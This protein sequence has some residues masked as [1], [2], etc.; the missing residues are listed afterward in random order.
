VHVGNSLPKVAR[1]V[2]LPDQLKMRLF[3]NKFIHYIR[4]PNGV[5]DI[6]KLTDFFYRKFRGKFTQI[7]VS[8]NA[9]IMENSLFDQTFSW[10]FMR[11]I[12]SAKIVAEDKNTHYMVT[13]EI[14]F[15]QSAIIY[16]ILMLIISAVMIVE[17]EYVFIFFMIL[18][19]AVGIFIFT[20]VASYHFLTILRNCIEESGLKYK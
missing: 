8:E 18:L 5:N 20:H 10:D 2:F 7:Y 16:I 4:C 6:R 17:S 19:W 12:S 13:S 15:Y 11:V 14:S 9:A 1:A 3:K